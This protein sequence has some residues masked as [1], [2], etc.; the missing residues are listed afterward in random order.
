MVNVT[1][2][3]EAWFSDTPSGGTL[4]P[5]RSEVLTERGRG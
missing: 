4:C 5:T 1:G 2:R 3:R